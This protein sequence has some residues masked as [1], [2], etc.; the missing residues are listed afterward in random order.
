M[1]RAAT[2]LAFGPAA[3]RFKFRR[4]PSVRL[5]NSGVFFVHRSVA[6]GSG[7]LLSANRFGSSSEQPRPGNSRNRRGEP[8]CQQCASQD[9]S[10][11]DAAFVAGCNRPRIAPK[12]GIAAFPGGYSRRSRPA[13]GAAQRA[14]AA[15]RRGTVCGGVKNK[16][17]STG[18]WRRRKFV[19][20]IAVDRTIFLLRR[21]GEFD[22]DR[23]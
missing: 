5:A 18:F 11:G 13:L 17:R 16:S 21:A 4:F 9:R 3:G 22:A 20:P 8:L 6:L 2:I 15:R 23:I 14:S 12:S 1:P 19:P 10:R 7:D